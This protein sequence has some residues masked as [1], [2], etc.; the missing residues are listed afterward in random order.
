MVG[1]AMVCGAAMRATGDAR[2]A[3]CYFRFGWGAGSARDA[4]GSPTVMALFS[5]MRPGA[6]LGARGFGMRGCPNRSR[7]LSRGDGVGN[8]REILAGFSRFLPAF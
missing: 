8:D 2:D 7:C 6:V 4:G 5:E 1:L 3:G